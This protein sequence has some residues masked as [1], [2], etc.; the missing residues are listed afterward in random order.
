MVFCRVLIFIFWPERSRHN[1][2]ILVDP[3]NQLNERPKL[4]IPQRLYQKFDKMSRVKMNTLRDSIIT[5]SF[6]T[7]LPICY[8]RNILT[9]LMW[10]WN[11]SISV[12]RIVQ[13]LEEINFL[14]NCTVLYRKRMF[15]NSSRM[16]FETNQTMLVNSD[17]MLH[18]FWP[19]PQKLWTMDGPMRLAVACFQ[20][21]TTAFAP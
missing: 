11:Y 9:V 5:F 17:M 20:V 14:Y 3:G 8:E 18:S 10:A 4:K 16:L 6:L 7:P 12:A 21:A 19:N 1:R 15:A 2:Q 13:T